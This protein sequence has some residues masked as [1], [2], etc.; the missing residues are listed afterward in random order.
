MFQQ[1]L[2]NYVNFGF[3]MMQKLSAHEKLV[4]MIGGHGILDQYSYLWMSARALETLL[5]RI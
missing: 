1:M 3:F 2:N 4:S 5:G